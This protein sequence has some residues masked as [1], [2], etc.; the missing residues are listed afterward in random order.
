MN[1]S[2]RTSKT[3]RLTCIL[4][5]LLLEVCILI[6]LAVPLLDIIGTLDR[7]EFPYD[8]LYI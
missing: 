2:K 7:F 1:R 6:E 5:Y 4:S 3:Y 8:N